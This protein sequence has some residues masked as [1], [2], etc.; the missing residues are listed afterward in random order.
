MERK[1]TQTGNLGAVASRTN[2]NEA[3]KLAVAEELRAVLARKQVTGREL[4]RRLGHNDHK[5]VTN[6]L[7][8]RTSIVFEDV[9]LLADAL[10]LGV[11]ELCG[12]L[13]DGLE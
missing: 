12:L 6:R 13:A 10:G 8:G 9:P 3:A 7:N 4:A 5:W 11:H 1:S 2:D